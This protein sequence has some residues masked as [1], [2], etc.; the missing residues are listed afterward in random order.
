MRHGGTGTGSAYNFGCRCRECAEANRLGGLRRRRAR[1]K[2]AKDP[3]DPRHGKSSFYTNHGCRC[4]KCSL[5]HSISC[6]E[7]YEKRKVAS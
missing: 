1:Y 2:E 3:N 6:K 4:E 5:A 7:R